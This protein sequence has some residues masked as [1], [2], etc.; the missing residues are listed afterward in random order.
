MNFV[1]RFKIHLRGKGIIFSNMQLK[2]KV[3][4]VTGGGSG[5]G[6]G[7]A[8]SLLSNGTKVW[9]KKL[10]LSYKLSFKNYELSNKH[11]FTAMQTNHKRNIIQ[12]YDFL[13]FIGGLCTSFVFIFKARLNS[14][15]GFNDYGCKHMKKYYIL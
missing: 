15:N 12:E 6:L 5:I 7:L 2:D 8:Y 9:F 1:T 10:F 13:W 14:L 4:L 3:A 11:T